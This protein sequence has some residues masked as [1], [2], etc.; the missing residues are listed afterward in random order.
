MTPERFRK[1]FQV[2]SLA[3]IEVCETGILEL[4]I[5]E[6]AYQYG[7]RMSTREDINSVSQMFDFT[8]LLMHKDSGGLIDWNS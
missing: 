5:E 3:I 1:A 2:W 8:K 4:S 6:L 7:A